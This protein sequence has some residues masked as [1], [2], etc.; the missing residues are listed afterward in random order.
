MN[1]LDVVWLG[2]DRRPIV[3]KSTSRIS[4]DATWSTLR[5]DL[6]FIATAI[7][8]ALVAWFLVTLMFAVTP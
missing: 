6:I 3:V 7:G 1:R 4:H 8:C 2:R 5:D